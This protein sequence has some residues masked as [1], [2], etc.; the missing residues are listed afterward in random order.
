ML[1]FTFSRFNSEVVPPIF[2]RNSAELLKY[3][4]EGPVNLLPRLQR[5][6]A[7]AAMSIDFGDACPYL[8]MPLR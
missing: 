3:C 8:D 4:P 5:T 2:E 7:E 1:K 6:V